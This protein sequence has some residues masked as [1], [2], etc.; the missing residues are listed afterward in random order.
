MQKGIF[1]EETEGNLDTAIGI[2]RDIILRADEARPVVAQAH[3]RLSFC[4]LKQGK[5]EE[6]VGA[7]RDLLARYS[8]QKE[9]ADKAH[10]QLA[11]LGAPPKSLAV[12]S[13]WRD[14]KDMGRVSLD[15]RFLP[16]VDWET[17]DLAVRHLETGKEERL[18]NKGSWSD[19]SEHCSNPVMSP[20][21]TRI[22]YVWGDARKDA[23]E[24][25]LFTL[26]DRTTRILAGASYDEEVS[27]GDWAPDGRHL[28][29][30]KHDRK[31][32]ETT[33][34]LLALETGEQKT[35]KNLGERSPSP[36]RFGPDGQRLAYSVRSSPERLDRDIYVIDLLSGKERCVVDDPA[37]DVLIG[38]A[39]D[40]ATLY[41]S[42][43]RRGP[44][45]IW[46]L[47]LSDGPPQVEPHLVYDNA[48]EMRSASLTR[49]GTLYYGTTASVHE[50][51]QVNTDPGMTRLI[52]E[53]KRVPLK[54]H[55]PLYFASWALRNRAEIVFQFPDDPALVGGGFS[56]GWMDLGSGE[57][58]R[59]APLRHL[60][61]FEVRPLADDQA[62]AI[63]GRM[64]KPGNPRALEW[65][66]LRS[67]RI[68]RI[69]EDSDQHR[70]LF[71]AVS[72]D[73]AVYYAREDRAAAR[74]E[75]VRYDLV[76]R[77]GTPTTLLHKS[78]GELTSCG[79]TWESHRYLYYS[80]SATTD[81]GRV[82]TRHIRR[83][84]ATGKELVCYE[85]S[86]P[87]Q[88]ITTGSG[89]TMAVIRRSP[90]GQVT[91]LEFL[92]ATENGV[93]V[94]CTATPPEGTQS[95][96]GFHT[97]EAKQ[98]RVIVRDG[99]GDDAPLRLWLMSTADG[100][101]QRTELVQPHG[102]R[103]LRLHPDGRQYLFA[104]RSGTAEIRALD[105]FVPPAP[106]SSGPGQGAQRKAGSPAAPNR[107]R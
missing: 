20:D 80:Y 39:W 51:F 34:D 35:L 24:L 26:S 82:Q 69:A 15:E 61:G 45:D 93:R 107:V 104:M 41:F 106:D 68:T 64:K 65:A 70:L 71:Y 40:G 8:D 101:L 55:A 47:H 94:R 16:F 50:V 90:A 25:R 44:W 92:D 46:S 14:A 75:W 13:V 3:Y 79:L 86:E 96:E 27:S 56:L 62:L 37:D 76:A 32:G 57:I 53:R 18:T 85:S 54:S 12:R 103:C 10:A 19:S 33:L 49:S 78:Q 2:Y 91:S 23:Y 63:F 74:Y 31:T 66:D 22:A 102:H 28:A 60:A 81:D 87:S 67:G 17:G 98:V 9:L 95:V 1:A 59:I 58:R 7:L 6:A 77:T 88:V 72:D 52:G 4:Y 43:D 105:H 30:A 11:Q 38:W 89:D 5:R 84:T 42:S 83:E 29:V 36:V 73:Q 48:G 21:G 99:T 100:S 97:P